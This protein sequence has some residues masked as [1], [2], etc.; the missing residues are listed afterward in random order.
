MH[1]GSALQNIA[2]SVPGFQGLN[3]ELASGLIGPEWATV[4]VNAV[5]DNNGRVS[6]RQGWDN[7]MSTTIAAQFKTIFEYV[8][9]DGSVELHGHAGTALYKST[10]S[11]AT[12]SAVTGTASPGSSE[13]VRYFNFNDQLVAIQKGEAPAIYTGTTFVTVADVNA[14]TGGVG[15]AAFG[16]MWIVDS[17]GHTL[18]YSALLDATDWTSSDS[19]SLDMFNIWPDTDTMT[20]VT[21]FNGGL[22]VFGKK[23]VIVWTD[24]AGSALGIDPVSMYVVDVLR[25]VGCVATDSVQHVD[26]DLWFL[27][28]VGLQS[29]GR[30]IQEKSNPIQNLSYNVQGQLL[31]YMSAANLALLRSAYS[32]RD[33]LY[34]L[35]FP[36][37]TYPETGRCFAFDTRGRLQD[38]S[39]RCMGTW[40]LVPT[41][42]T[43]RRSGALGL[44]TVGDGTNANYGVYD[45]QLDDGSSYL[46]DYE[47]GWLDVTKAG[48]KIIPKKYTGVF[49]TDN[50]ITVGFK[51]AL[52][53]SDAFTTRSRTFTS[54][55]VGGGEWGSGEWAVAEFGGGVSLLTGGVNSSKTG[56]YI[57]IGLA[58][59]INN[60]VFSVQ[61]LD[62]YCK[63]G[64]MA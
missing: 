61:Q 62:L 2:M 50:D 34:L 30:L 6:A 19:G 33:R 13:P 24:G 63:I 28:D 31:S 9:A 57:K 38:G 5:I 64:R 53:F 58:V 59:T 26:A 11:G 47:S 46:F 12:W 16:R 49:F 44:Q 37:G 4:L 32:P 22:V 54:G 43:V 55:A 48:Y 52:D 29:F 42:M 7:A 20:A 40:T 25:G 35:S 27:S 56:E 21:S 36:S 10:D 60:T 8:K 18:Q 45:G 3:T 23:S 1:G 51:Y 41:A 39:A 15:T 17:D 14:P